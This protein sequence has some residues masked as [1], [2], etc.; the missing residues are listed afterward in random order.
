MMF[1]KER[2]KRET[3]IK[4]TWREIQ[5][6]AQQE[7]HFVRKA[8][9]RANK[10][11]S[12]LLEPEPPP[13][14]YL[15]LREPAEWKIFYLFL[16]ER[17]A[18]TDEE[19]EKIPEMDL[20]KKVGEYPAS[21]VYPV[22]DELLKE[23]NFASARKAKDWFKKIDNAAQFIVLEWRKDVSRGDRYYQVARLAD[24]F[25]NELEEIYKAPD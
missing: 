17:F 2:E 3:P 12:E 19:L 25:G 8:L 18:R 6:R 21:I 9:E 4:D 15:G 14:I 13:I 10:E 16:L 7:H 5:R 11:C 20:R 23:L 22:M 1:R 24:R